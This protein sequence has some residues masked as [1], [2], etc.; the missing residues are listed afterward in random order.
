MWCS[1]P[2]A[3]GSCQQAFREGREPPRAASRTLAEH[4]LAAE[5]GAGCDDAEEAAGLLAGYTCGVP[6][7]EA[8]I[9]RRVTAAG[10]E[11]H[12]Q[13]RVPCLPA[14][15]PAWISPVWALLRLPAPAWL[16]STS[17]LAC[18]C[19]ARALLAACPLPSCPAARLRPALPGWP[20]TPAPACPPVPF[21]TPQPP[22]SV[23]CARRA[24]LPTAPCRCWW[25]CSACPAS[26][27]CWRGWQTAHGRR[28]RGPG[29]CRSSWMACWARWGR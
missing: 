3:L 1:R 19:F 17:T 13:V 12:L 15:P 7:A 25:P 20:S 24:C 9:A 18:R 26:T 8:E 27:G 11:A 29:S 5:E 28:C 23:P 4:A 14:C 16:G 22:P 6:Q 21:P 10:L 2:N